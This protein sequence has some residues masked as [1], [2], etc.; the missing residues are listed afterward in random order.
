MN[1]KAFIRLL[2]AISPPDVFNPYRDTCP[3]HDK[4]SGAQIRVRN[5]RKFLDASLRLRVDTIWMGRDLGYRGGR[6]TGIALTDEAHLPTIA[7]RF[8]DCHLEKATRGEVVAERTATEIWSALTA[9]PEAPFLWNVFPLHPHE[10]SMPMTNRK[11]SRSELKQVEAV[12][13]LLISGMGI[14]RIIAIGQDAARYAVRYCPNVVAIRHP[15]YGGVSDF[16][17]GVEECYGLAPL[18]LSTSPHQQSLN[19]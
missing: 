16:R 13:D 2:E 12:N 8:P 19:F 7:T 17:R 5:L 18:T 9:V 1:V 10:H 3:I 4:A 14:K 15:S 11:F 6:R